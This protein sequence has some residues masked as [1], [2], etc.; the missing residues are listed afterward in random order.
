MYIQTT[1]IIGRA[2]AERINYWK[3]VG[4][5]RWYRPFALRVPIL[6]LLNCLL[7]ELELSKG[8]VRKY[9]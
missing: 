6:V 3:W 4:T 7:L 1:G 9:H 2:C 8:S 5:R